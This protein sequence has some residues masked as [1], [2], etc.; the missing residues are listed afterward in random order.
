MRATLLLLALL[1]LGCQ[2]RD[3]WAPRTYSAPVVV[4]NT[5]PDGMVGQPYV[6]TLAATGGD[7]RYIWKLNSPLP[8]GLVLDSLTG[9]ISGTPTTATAPGSTIRIAAASNG[10]PVTWRP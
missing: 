5:L 9:V 3:L 4:T 1:A 2:D 7:G 10:G 6:H 8:E